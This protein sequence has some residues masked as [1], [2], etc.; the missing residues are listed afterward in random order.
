M[1]WRVMFVLASVLGLYAYAIF[2]LGLFGLLTKSS[3]IIVTLIFICITLAFQLRKQSF[4][5]IKKRDVVRNRLIV[6]SCLILGIQSI[7]NLIGALGPELAFDALW[8][9]LTLPKLYV[10]AERISFI[11]GNLLYYSAMPKLGEMFYVAALSV[12]NEI[13]AKVIHFSFGILSL[14]TL[15]N[16]ARKFLKTELSV[17]V[18][19]IYFANLVVAWESTTAYIDLIR[20]FFELMAFWGFYNWFEKGNNKWLYLS[21]L[22]LGFA[23]ATKLLALGSVLIFLV[24]IVYKH[25]QTKNREYPALLKDIISFVGISLLIP[26]PW[27]LFSYF[28]TGNPVYPFF[29]DLYPVNATHSML[30]PLRFITDTFNILT[31]A[32]DPISPIYLICL[33]LIFLI[34]LPQKAKP[35]LLYVCSAF[36]IWYLTP[37]SGGGR[38]LL[39]YLPVFSLLVGLLLA[40][41]QSQKIIRQ[42]LLLI[43]FVIAL[44]TVVYRGLTNSRYVP[45]LTGQQ[46]KYAFLSKNLNFAYGDFYDTDNY[47]AKN[48]KENDRVLLYGFHN[49]YYV[50]FP[51]IHESWLKEGDR[52]NYIAVQNG[53]LP[54]EY[55]NFTMIYENEVTKVKLYS[56]EQYISIR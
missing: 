27:F 38:F 28:H 53:E 35:V 56:L 14:I 32:A 4:P 3:I 26:L 34:T 9:H 31:N 49:L 30:N 52:Y 18:L 45:V 54:K 37:R 33:P 5:F 44:S 46:S 2:V 39:P 36:L 47:F 13:L 25:K 41:L 20:T 16:V 51:Y 48:I 29:T 6:F 21:A 23:I 24:L 1:S 11:P 22:L 17:I 7:I 55:S 12:S 42:V 8:Y 50:N 43:I 40:Q 10:A 19:V 15:Y